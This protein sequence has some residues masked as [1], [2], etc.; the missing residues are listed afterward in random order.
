MQYL[1]YI[2]KN[3]LKYI[4]VFVSCIIS[5][6]L[7]ML[8]VRN[9][10]PLLPTDSKSGSHSRETIA[11]HYWF[12]LGSHGT[13]PQMV[14]Y[15][16]KI[17]NGIGYILTH[18][19]A[20]AYLSGG[21]VAKP[22]KAEM[23]KLSPT[24]TYIKC[25][26]MRA[27]YYNGF[28]QSMETAAGQVGMDTLILDLRDGGIASTDEVVKIANQLIFNKQLTLTKV[29]FFNGEEIEIKSR[30]D[31]FY[32]LQFIDIWVSDI[33]SPAALLMAGMVRSNAPSMISGYLKK[34][35]IPYYTFLPLGTDH[36]LYMPIGMCAI[37]EKKS[38]SIDRLM[39]DKDMDAISHPR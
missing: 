38:L 30:G 39:S 37:G 3:Y 26:D 32:P 14:D 1:Q 4:P 21:K 29:H 7:F 25:Y 11:N 19:Q 22:Q 15:N 35:E 2:N 5:F 18:S 36:F 13:K 8:P 23:R 6:G 17:E 24:T 34:Q 27:G 20:L 28:M 9:S 31:V 33:S 10:L 16:G 12:E